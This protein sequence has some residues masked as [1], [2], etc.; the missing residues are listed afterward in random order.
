MGLIAAF[1]P[2]RGCCFYLGAAKN[3][4]HGS[5]ERGKKPL[6]CRHDSG[7]RHPH[8]MCPSK[9]QKTLWQ[10]SAIQYTSLSRIQIR[11]ICFIHTMKSDPNKVE[12][13]KRWKLLPTSLPYS[14]KT[15]PWKLLPFHFVRRIGIWMFSGKYCGQLLGI[16]YTYESNSWCSISFFLTEY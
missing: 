13:A 3:S 11:N 6:N 8:I 7:K 10:T 12:T 14:L 5:G 15:P 9:V 2:L 4:T 1:S 16:W